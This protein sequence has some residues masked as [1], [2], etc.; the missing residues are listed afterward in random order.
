MIT[1][2]QIC[3]FKRVL[4]LFFFFA[5][6]IFN[7]VYGQWNLL[8]DG[9]GGGQKTQIGFGVSSLY[10]FNLPKP[11]IGVHINTTIEDKDIEIRGKT[12]GTFYKL[13]ASYFFRQGK[14]TVG[15]FNAIST[16]DTIVV[17][18]KFNQTV[19]YLMFE[20]GR[21]FYL[22]SNKKELIFL[23]GG[24]IL[25]ANIPFYRADYELAPFDETNYIL[26]TENGWKKN[27]K[28]GQ[29]IFKAGINIGVDFYV[30][31]RGQ[32]YLETTPFVN[33]TSEK[34]LK[35]DINIGSRF[36]LGLNLGYRYEL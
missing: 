2:R 36:F 21:D 34:Y 8:F 16:S 12:Q 29:A 28:E 20:I 9:T 25:G 1:L 5:T 18:Y 7:Q 35:P 30:G 13:N 32:L 15:S 3:S 24:W 23:Y 19:S 14:Q 31:M 27:R 22:F 4:M 26:Q 11:L 10:Q 17:P 6:T 33:V